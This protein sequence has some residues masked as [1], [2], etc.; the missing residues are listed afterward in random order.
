MAKVLEATSH[1]NITRR[2]DNSN[3]GIASPSFKVIEIVQN[4]KAQKECLKKEPLKLRWKFSQTNFT[5]ISQVQ[6]VQTQRRLQR[7]TVFRR[8]LVVELPEK[9]RFLCDL[10]RHHDLA[11]LKREL[12]HLVL[13]HTSSTRKLYFHFAALKGRHSLDGIATAVVG[14]SS[15]AVV[16]GQRWAETKGALHNLGA[17]GTN[18]PISVIERSRSVHRQPFRRQTPHRHH[19]TDM[20]TSSTNTSSA[21]ILS[22]EGNF[23][24]VRKLMSLV[25]V[26]SQDVIKSF[27]DV[28]DS[29][30]YQQHKEILRPF[31]DYFEDNWIGRPSRGNRLR[32]P[33]V[34]LEM[35]NQYERTLV[36]LPKT[37]DYIEG[38]H[39]KFSSLV[40]CYQPSI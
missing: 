15:E 29:Q 26:P 11:I 13:R 24:N 25:F 32:P 35:W 1:F 31:M 12:R 5:C 6:K 2:C 30:F 40:G 38:W 34:S 23:L 39:R 16:Q 9:S 22:T 14:L 27:E 21:A 19:F 3:K 4:S 7:A 17:Q 8:K 10:R 28:A 20:D 36:G 33:S 18:V 37:N